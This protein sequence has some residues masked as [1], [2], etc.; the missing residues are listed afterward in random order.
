M[1]VT[2]ISILLPVKNAASFLPA[3]LDSIINQTESDWELIAI[4]D[5]SSDESAK[6]LEAYAKSDHRISTYRNKGHG[7]IPALQFAYQNSTGAFIT[8]M[9]ADDVMKPW[10]LASLQN[11]LLERGPGHLSTGLV[12]YISEG[13]LGAGYLRYQ[14][15]LNQ[16]SRKGSN[17]QEI[18]K[19]CVIPSPC[20][21]VY[22]EDLQK[23][24][25]FDSNRY[26]EDYDLCFRFFAAGL[27][28]IPVSNVLHE[29][30][31]HPD[32]A[33]RNDPNYLDHRFLNLKVFWFLKLHHDAGRPLV[34]WG[35]GKK[36]K[37][38]AKLLIQKGIHFN[39]ICN[40]EKKI[41]SN[42]FDVRMHPIEHID[43]LLE[44]QVIIAV[45]GPT[46]QRGIINMLEKRQKKPMQDY[47]LFC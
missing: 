41:G 40:N 1:R 37:G 39:W 38:I 19:E 45:A 32:R 23:C 24:G 33:S 9:D 7:I 27:Q 13:Q 29:W 2:S 16:L 17:Y 36:G 10:K 21:M 25:A 30:R 20:W 3:C 44:P 26:P 47:Y 11:D 12:E 43:H 4:D 15:W 42:I 46:E 6:I 28:C 31:D 5:H 18:Y 35:A 34:L 8:R 14:Q 22:R